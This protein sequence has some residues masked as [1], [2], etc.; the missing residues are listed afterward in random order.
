MCFKLHKNGMEPTKHHSVLC[1]LLSVSTNWILKACSHNSCNVFF[2]FIC[3][4]KG[5]YPIPPSGRVFHEV[6][7]I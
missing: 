2:K 4:V 3:E 7:S 5:I 1:R 6:K